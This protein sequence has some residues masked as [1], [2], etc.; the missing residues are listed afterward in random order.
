MDSLAVA[1]LATCVVAGYL[2]SFLVA[3]LAGLLVSLTASGAHNFFHQ[4]HSW[5][6]YLFELSFM[7]SREWMVSHAL[8]HHIFTN[9]MQDLEI[10]FFEPVIAFLPYTDK[11][12]VVRYASWAYCVVL[13]AALA[14]GQVAKR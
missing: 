4:K 1:A 6:R 3:V 9:T 11:P 8:S 12:A 2:N 7:S 5:R 13:Y 10:T 14:H